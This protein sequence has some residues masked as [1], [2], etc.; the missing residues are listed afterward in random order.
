MLAGCGS[1]NASE[2]GEPSS[3][4]STKNPAECVPLTDAALTPRASPAIQNR[5]T[6]YL[7]DVR[8][9]TNRCSERVIFEFEKGSPPG[10]GF[11]I[12]YQPAESAKIEDGSGNQIEIDGSA[13]LVVRL[14]PAMTAR[15]SG[16]KV[17]PTYTGPRRITPEGFSFVRQVVKTGDFEAQITW[18]IGLDKQRPFATNASESQ[19]VVE[20]G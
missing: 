15:I 7:S 14:M 1:G 4:S 3:S 20:F 19:L 17:E 2:Q 12:S 13:F 8:L 16:E 11:N 18:V 6:T 5:E 9:E 10:P